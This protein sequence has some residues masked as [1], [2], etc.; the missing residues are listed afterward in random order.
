M[1]E[2][3]KRNHRDEKNICR[4]EGNDV[5]FKTITSPHR[6]ERQGNSR[7]RGIPAISCKKYSGPKFF[8]FSS[9]FQPSSCSSLW[10]TA[11]S[12]RIV[13]RSSKPEYCFQFSSISLRFRSFPEVE[14][15]LLGILWSKSWQQPLTMWFLHH[16]G[17]F[18]W[19]KIVPVV[20]YQMTMQLYAS[21]RLTKSDAVF[22]LDTFDINRVSQ[23]SWSLC[24]CY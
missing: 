5:F 3:E 9:A 4:R 12:R 20:K 19:Q 7:F 15:I 13:P 10:D 21:S 11:G 2:E 23:K 17:E 1:N 8:G 14:I 22:L 24:K 16:W 6:T 18:V